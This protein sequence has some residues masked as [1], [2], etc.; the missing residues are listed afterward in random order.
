MIPKRVG[1]GQ[2]EDKRERS[3]EEADF[4]LQNPELPNGCEVTSLAMALSAAGYPVDKLVLFTQYMPSEPFTLLDGVR[5]GP[6]P[7][8]FYAGNAASQRGGWYCLEGPVMRAGSRWL[9]ENGAPF[10]MERCSGLTQSTLA[11][12][13]KREILLI[14]WVTRDYAPLEYADY[15]HWT[16]PDGTDYTPY[17]NLHC[18]LLVGETEEGCQIADPLV[19]IQLVEKERLWQSFVSLG[20]RAVAI[21]KK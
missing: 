10:R 1:D 4:I 5:H 9:T 18:V 13:L 19:G 21:V 2:M 6:S 7:E 3:F 17:N 11:G 8:E 15:F 20:R 16:L 14:I 12:Y